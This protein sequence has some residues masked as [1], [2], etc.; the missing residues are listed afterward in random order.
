M[1]GISARQSF[2]RPNPIISGLATCS[3]H[4]Q[5]AGRVGVLEVRD[6]WQTR[7]PIVGEQVVT[8]VTKCRFCGDWCKPSGEDGLCSF[9]ASVAESPDKSPDGLAFKLRCLTARLGPWQRLVF[10]PVICVPVVVG[11]CVL[12]SLWHPLVTQDFSRFGAM[13]YPPSFLV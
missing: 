10:L 5:E 11:I 7:T 3:Q 2:Q 9:C 4:D 8:P 6:Y 13:H 1:E 12:A